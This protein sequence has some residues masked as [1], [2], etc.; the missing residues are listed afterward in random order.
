[1]YKR[2]N[3]Y[4]NE[5]W[6]G[7]RDRN[8]MFL[9]FFLSFSEHQHLSKITGDLMVHISTS[10]ITDF[11]LL[12]IFST[13]VNKRREINYT[14]VYIIERKRILNQ[15]QIILMYPCQTFRTAQQKCRTHTPNRMHFNNG[16]AIQ[17]MDKMAH[18][19]RCR[20]LPMLLLLVHLDHVW[21][22]YGMS[23]RP[24]PHQVLHLALCWALHC[25][26]HASVS[27]RFNYSKV[28][29]VL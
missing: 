7:Q 27:Q 24:P 16:H 11:H 3:L 17:L 21:S 25:S 28:L 19:N 12:L 2:N 18:R 5:Q 8:F 26:S 22:W 20:D 6:L 10:Q 29:S 13:T 23:R 15:S 1:M 4:F 9:V 14:E